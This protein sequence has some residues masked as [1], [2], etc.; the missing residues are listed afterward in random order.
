MTHVVPVLVIDK[1]YPHK[2]IM[3][4]FVYDVMD[5]ELDIES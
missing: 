5:Y 1:S 3:V 4:S 2:E